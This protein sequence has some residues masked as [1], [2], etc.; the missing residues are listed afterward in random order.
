METKAVNTPI[1]VHIS[2]DYV[3]LI[4]LEPTWTKEELQA[5]H[6]IDP[7]IKYMLDSGHQFQRRIDKEESSRDSE[8]FID[9]TEKDFFIIKT[10][11]YYGYGLDSE[12]Q[13]LD[14]VSDKNNNHYLHSSQDNI[15]NRW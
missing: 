15:K 12:D 4:S 10:I 1:P 2:D 8:E 14:I 7:S 3:Y 9:I 13:Y 11:K 6:N 5:F